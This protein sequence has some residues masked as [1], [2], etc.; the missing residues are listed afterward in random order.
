MCGL[1]LLLLSFLATRSRL[2]HS[3]T[4]LVFR[5]PRRLLQQVAARITYVTVYNI[6]ISLCALL[7]F[8]LGQARGK[9]VLVRGGIGS[10]DLDQVLMENRRPRERARSAHDTVSC[11][12]CYLAAPF[13]PQASV[14]VVV[15]TRR[16][17]SRTLPYFATPEIGV[18]THQ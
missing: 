7:V 1:V 11:R 17:V 10:D 16:L 15:H 6:S 4:T 18:S 14:V 13:P 5:L 8:L 12:V 3:L 2:R 9:I